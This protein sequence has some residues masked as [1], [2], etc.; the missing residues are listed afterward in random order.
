MLQDEDCCTLGDSHTQQHVVEVVK[1]LVV[2]RLIEDLDV[3]VHELEREY[4]VD[5]GFFV[6]VLVLVILL[7]D[8]EGGHIGV[9]VVEDHDDQR[10]HDT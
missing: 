9:Q 1:I 5:I 8:R 10:I 4:L 3:G 2:E 6:G 7:V